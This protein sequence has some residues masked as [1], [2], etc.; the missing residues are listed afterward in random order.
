[1]LGIPN[2]SP[3]YQRQAECGYREGAGDRG[4]RAVITTE[5]GRAAAALGCAWLGG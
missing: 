4:R 3:F 2:C 5:A 1:M